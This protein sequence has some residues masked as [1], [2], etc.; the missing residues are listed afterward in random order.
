MEAIGIEARDAGTEDALVEVELPIG[1]EDFGTA[2]KDLLADRRGVLDAADGAGRADEAQGFEVD[3]FEAWAGFEAV[4]EAGR[5]VRADGVDFGEKGGEEVRV[6]EDV[7][8]HP[9]AGFVGVGVD[10]TKGVG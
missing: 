6:V 10:A 4:F 7:G 3:G 2:A 1:D 8:E 5:L 9:E